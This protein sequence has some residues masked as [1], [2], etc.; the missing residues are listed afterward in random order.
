MK[1]KRIVICDACSIIFLSK[2][3]YLKNIQSIFDGKILVPEIILKKVLT[4]K[5]S[6]FEERVV[7]N[8]IKEAKVIKIKKGNIKSKAL[9][10]SDNILLSFSIEKKVDFLL[11]D[12]S[13]I[14]KIVQYEKIKV[15][16]TL[17]IILKSVDLGLISSKEA[18]K[19]LDSL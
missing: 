15:I 18:K 3:D 12:D 11:S 17:G 13:M 14:R 9:S 8:F 1:K 16:G 10:L 6:P 19:K 4:P 5:I 7:N 2:I